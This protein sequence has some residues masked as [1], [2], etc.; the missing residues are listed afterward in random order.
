MNK[1]RAFF[2]LFFS[3]F[4]LPVFAVI[5]NAGLISA[6]NDIEADVN[7]VSTAIFPVVGIVLGFIFGIT[8]FKHFANW[9]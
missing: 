3:A 2:L 5:P 6:M 8:L 9:V 7:A 1:I 4:S